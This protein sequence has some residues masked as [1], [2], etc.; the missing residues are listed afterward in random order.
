MVPQEPK[1][2]SSAAMKS[3]VDS[4]CRYSN[5]ST[6]AT[7]GLSSAGCRPV[8]T[9]LLAVWQADY[10]AFCQRDLAERDYV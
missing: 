7:F 1:N 6:S 10:Q 8:I 5:G 3:P 2:P 9:R 4:P